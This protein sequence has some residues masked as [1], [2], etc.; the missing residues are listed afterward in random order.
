MHCLNCDRLL[1]D[2]EATRKHAITFKFLDLCKVCFEDVKTIIPTIDRKELMT[3]QDLDVND[4]DET[5]LDT[6]A[7]LEDNEA[8][9]SY[10]DTAKLSSDDYD[11]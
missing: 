5:D 11:V 10:H 7:S 9:Y 1:T 6:G 2:Y 8:L 3:D 4:D